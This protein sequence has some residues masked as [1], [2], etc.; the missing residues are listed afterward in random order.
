MHGM[1]KKLNLSVLQKIIIAALLK[2][3]NKTGK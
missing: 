1:K 3:A 2:K